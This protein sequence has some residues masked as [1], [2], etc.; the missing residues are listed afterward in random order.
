MLKLN[1]KINK[2][3]IFESIQYKSLYVYKNI[4]I[5]SKFSKK[6][7]ANQ[8]LNYLSQKAFCNII[9]KYRNIGISAHIDSGK[10]TFTERVLFYTGKIDKIHEVKG[11]DKIGAKMDSMELERERGITI[12]SAATYCAWKNHHINIID[13]PGHVD[14]TIEVERALKVLDGAVL[15]ICGASGVQPQTLTV[16]KQM[17]RYNLPRII[18]I[19]KL[20]RAGANPQLAISQIK[21]RLNLNVAAV[22]LPIGIESDF[23]GLIDIIELK[24]YYFDGPNGEYIRCEN[25]PNDYIEV[26]KNARKELIESVAEVNKDL[27]ELYLTLENPIDISNDILKKCIRECVIQ[28]KFYPVFMGSA[29]KNKGIQNCLDGIVDYLPNPL[30]KTQK[31]FL[32]KEILSKQE[33]QYNLK[34]K[35]IEKPQEIILN[36]ENSKPFIGLAFKLQEN[37]YGQLTFIRAYQGIL[38]RGDLLNIVGEKKKVKVSRLVRMHVDEMEEILEVQCGEIFAIFG[39]DCNSGETFSADE[40]IIT[41]E[42]MHVPEPVMSLS[43][44]PRKTDYITKFLKAINRFQREDPTFRVFQNEETDEMIMSG[45]G[46][47]HLQIYAERI[48]R[49]YDIEVD[50]GTPQVNYRESISQIGNFNYLHKKQSGGAGQFARVIGYIEPLISDFSNTKNI[51]NIFDD[52][53]GGQNIPNEY[54]S[55]IEKA[56][57]ESCKKGPIIGAPIIGVKYVLED[58]QTH[59]VDSSSLAFG[60]AAKYS[61]TEAFRS[62]HPILLEPIMEVE[63]SGPSE[64]QTGIMN[65][66]TKRKG[67]IYDMTT[68]NDIFICKAEVSLSNMFGY[69]TELRNVTQGVG[70]FSMEYKCHNPLPPYE[71]NALLEKKFKKNK[72]I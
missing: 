29:I 33:I 42:K 11:T 44:R 1:L 71:L 58:G 36:N 34:Q 32:H 66:L 41:I 27:E 16:N 35:E 26:S 46:E 47:L 40:R 15:L 8:I 5:E 64:Y 21:N 54:I 61:M 19:N 30:E 12:Q 62:A 39:I 67:N 17:N 53:T 43:I 65:T 28:Q 51:F 25:I 63:V 45:M 70:E 49:E 31:A 37:Q 68:Q 55:A 9:K 48:R 10:T 6:Q 69:A 20:D 7:F 50:V 3:Y 72:K 24:A 2:S 52:K 59:P 14:F 57:H 4:L 13:T 56:F 38:K 18:F 60:L 22:Q 23:K